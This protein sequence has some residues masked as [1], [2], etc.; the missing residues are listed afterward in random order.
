MKLLGV[1]DWIILV[2]TALVLLYLYAARYRNYWKEQNV[3]HEDFSLIFATAKQMLFKPFFQMDLDRY[4]KYGRLFGAYEGGKPVL[5]V[6]DPEL[7]KLVLV[8]DFASL[9][10]RRILSFGDSLLDNMMSILPVEKWRR[11]RPAASPAFSTGKLRKMNS[12][13]ADCARTTAEHLKET[14]EKEGE[15]DLKQFYANYA[16]DVI[17][18]CAFATRL[19]SHSD[20]TNEFVTKAKQAISSGITLRLVVAF[21]FPKVFK[22]LKLKALNTEVFLYFKNLCLKIIANR[23]ETRGRQDDFLQLMMDA[24]DGVLEAAAESTSSANEKLFNLDSEIKADTSFEGGAKALTE[25]EAMAQC[26]LFFVAGQESTSSVLAFTLYLLALHPEVQ[27][28]LREEADECFR[29]HGPD[30]S[31][32]VVSK[33]K[34]LHGVVSGSL[35]MFPPGPRFS[36]ENIDSIRPYTY[37]PFGAGPRNCIGMKFALEAVKLSLLHSVHSVEFVRTNNTKEL[38]PDLD[39][40]RAW[41]ILGTHVGRGN[42]WQ[43][44]WDGLE[45]RRLWGVV[46]ARLDS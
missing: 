25:E 2:A 26:I 42:W 1:P 34:Y 5:F 46:S 35:R 39:P 37:L 17:A 24:Q 9:P 29:Q 19:D 4:T 21:L 13:I 7:V 22:L 28:K 36:E 20:E 18:R 12:L 8:K 41:S 44:R 3:V 15:L 11:I 40:S 33:L 38:R 6:A 27:A 23:K 10:N 43:Q 14:A 30:P 45:R 16:L 32:D 31:L